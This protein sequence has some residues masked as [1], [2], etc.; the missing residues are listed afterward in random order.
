MIDSSAVLPVMP[1]KAGIYDLSSLRQ[2]KSWMPACAG[3]TGG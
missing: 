3:M 2:R 1:A